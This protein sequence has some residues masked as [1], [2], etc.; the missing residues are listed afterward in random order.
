MAKK[1]TPKK[2]QERSRSSRRYKTFQGNAQK[3]LV[4]LTSL[5]KCPKC[6]EPKLSHMACPVCG[7]YK[8]RSVIDKDKE[9]EKITKVKA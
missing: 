3:R 1:S 5:S 6:K 7:E 8:G 4:K 2:R 9:V